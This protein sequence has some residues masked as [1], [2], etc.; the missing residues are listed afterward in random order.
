MACPET[1]ARILVLA[2]ILMGAACSIVE[3]EAIAGL[4]DGDCAGETKTCP[5]PG[6][7]DDQQCVS[8]LDPTTS[9]GVVGNCAPCFFLNGSSTCGPDGTCALESCDFG[10]RNCL[11]EVGPDVCQT[12]TRS[13][14]A[15]CGDCSRA[16]IATNGIAGCVN[17]T[18]TI[19]CTPGFGNCNQNDPTVG[20]DDGC[21]TPLDTVERCGDCD[22]VCGDGQSCVEGECV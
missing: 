6:T 8:I 9:C 11:N 4:T 22:T 2:G 21:E 1:A 3:G 12:D 19:V 17:A 13:D 14:P 16:C 5:V 20:D 10:F 7:F 15:H 18:C